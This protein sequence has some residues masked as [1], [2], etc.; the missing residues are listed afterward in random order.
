MGTAKDQAIER[1]I[2]EFRQGK[3]TEQRLR[4]ALEGRVDGDS[5]RQDLLYLQALNDYAGSG[6]FGG[7]SS[8]V[9]GML[10]LENGEHADAPEDPDDWPYQTVAEAI[11]DGWRVIKFPEMA[12][13]L[14]E[15][16][17]YGLGCEYI[18]ERWS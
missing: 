18:L 14:S 15:E 1:Y 6:Q 13:L 8:Q 16:R 3:L 4:Q 7:T 17:Y 2:E 9:V 11:Q 12:L 5:K 10:L